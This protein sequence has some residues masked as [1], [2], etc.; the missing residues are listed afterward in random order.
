VTSNVI[1]RG[2]P[3]VV[4]VFAEWIIVGVS[5]I[6]MGA[7]VLPFFTSVSIL[8]NGWL[9]LMVLMV[10]F[11]TARLFVDL[12]AREFHTVILTNTHLTRERGILDRDR[13][14]IPLDKVQTVHVRYALMGRIL[15][16]GNLIVSTAGAPIKIRNLPHP[17]EWESAIQSRM[18]T[19]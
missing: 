16:Y 14:V 19:G 10:L 3:S 7:V 8:F 11:I 5:I 4:P 1:L 2:K 13:D 17:A 18:R 9:I 15:D 12:I 6:I